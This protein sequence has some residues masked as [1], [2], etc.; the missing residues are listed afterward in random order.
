[1]ADTIAAIATPPGQGGVGI[2][3]ISGKNACSIAEKISQ[4]QSFEPRKI[5]F[6]SFFDDQQNLIDQGL[7]IYFKNTASFTG[8]DVV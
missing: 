6:A 4:L 2:V 8:E 1:M 5:H 3:R 7:L